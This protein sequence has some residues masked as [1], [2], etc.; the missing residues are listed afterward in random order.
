MQMSKIIFS[1]TN[2]WHAKAAI[3][4]VND[5]DKIEFIRHHSLR[6]SEIDD[7]KKFI[8]EC[9]PV[10]DYL[11][12]DENNSHLQK[13][14]TGI[15]PPGLLYI[16]KDVIVYEKPPSYQ[17]VFVIPKLVNDIS[18][19][20]DEPTVYRIPIPWQ[21]YMVHHSDF[22]TTNVRMHFMNNSLMDLD[23]QMYLAP[24]SNFYSSGDLCRPF[25]SSMDDIER[26]PKN[27]S[28]IMA[29]SYDWV[30]NSGTNLDLTQCIVAF[31]YQ[32]YILGSD[33]HNN[34]LLKNTNSKSFPREAFYC[35][36]N[37][38]SHLYSNW[39][40]FELH[41]VSFLNWPKNSILTSFNDDYNK[42]KEEKLH[43][44]LTQ[45]SSTTVHFTPECCEECSYLD[46]EGNSFDSDDCDCSCHD[47]AQNVNMDSFYEWAGVTP[48]SGV[49]FIQS[50]RNF[51]DNNNLNNRGSSLYEVISNQI[52][53][54]INTENTF[55]KL[56]SQLVY[57]S[58]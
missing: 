1:I 29:S 56:Y 51:R 2:G 48:P 25:F 55:N 38:A 32:D 41:E 8:Q 10:L 4:C 37:Y 26:Y 44:Y 21:L 11:T 17:N 12:F 45:L 23:Q 40:K 50:F 15:I 18:Y 39:E 35:S 28:G 5:D 22:T 24:L 53:S 7:N 58:I 27:V 14:D 19:D 3:S 6:I 34:S 52:I 31:F 57:S 13:K 20:S 46:D 47:S 33:F 42:I 9:S 36:P 54:S 16:D 49:S 30:W 43:E